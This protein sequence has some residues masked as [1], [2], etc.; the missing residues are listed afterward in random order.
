MCQDGE[1]E[2]T[3]LLNGYK[4]ASR[5]NLRQV[6]EFFQLQWSAAVSDYLLLTPGQIR[7]ILNDDAAGKYVWLFKPGTIC[8]AN[9]DVSETHRLLKHLEATGIRI[10]FAFFSAYNETRTVQAAHSDLSGTLQSLQLHA[11]VMAKSIE[12]KKLETSV[13]AI[14]DRSESFIVDLHHGLSHP[15]RP[16]FIATNIDI[17]KLQLDIIHSQK[18]LD[19]PVE[20][21]D[22]QMLRE[23]YDHL[24]A[25]YDLEKRFVNLQEKIADL[26]TL[27]TSY[28]RLGFRHK[29]HRLYLFEVILLLMFP[30]FSLIHI[31]LRRIL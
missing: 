2:S 12:L 5:P 31:L 1:M 26:N 15:N 18:I 21:G 29:E 24:A 23:L 11:V 14:I 7:I 13:N 10:N 28:H 20:C 4:I 16:R 9:F 27:L 25:D 17:I 6:S 22:E 19:R 30:L 3:V 8:I